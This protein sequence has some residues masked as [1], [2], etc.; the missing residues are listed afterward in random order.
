[1]TAFLNA[2]I[3]LALKIGINDVRISQT[4][5]PFSSESI[6][7]NAFGL[8]SKPRQQPINL[9]ALS[10]REKPIIQKVIVLSVPLLFGTLCILNALSQLF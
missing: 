9:P 3:M 8:V 4:D 1:M 2:L 10:L 5:H 6:T 7:F